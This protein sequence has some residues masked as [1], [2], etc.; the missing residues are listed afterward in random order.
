M[1]KVSKKR[2]I[3]ESDSDGSDASDLDQELLSLAS[4]AKRQKTSP[5]QLPLLT[6]SSSSTAAAAAGGGV[7]QSSGS[8]S[9]SEN[10]SDGEWNP[11]SKSK[12]AAAVVKV[13]KPAGRVPMKGVPHK[14]MGGASGGKRVV[15]RHSSSD[16]SD[17]DDEDVEGQG[18]P[19]TTLPSSTSGAAS[20]SSDSETSG[21]DDNDDPLAKFD[22][23][24]DEELVGDDEDRLKL[25][26]M[27][28]AER[29]Q[30]MYNR[31]EKR[32]ALKARFEIEQKL[33]RERKSKRSRQK[34]REERQK[35]LFREKRGKQ[36]DKSKSR[37]MDELKA[38]RTADKQ[39]KA[40]AEKQQQQRK[41]EP[42]KAQ[43]VYSSESEEE[44]ST[45]SSSTGSGGDSDD[46][47][48]DGTMAAL[49][50]ESKFV[51]KLEE[52][53]KIRLSR[54]RMEKW[55]HMPF[56]AETLIGCFARVGIG[57]HDGRMVYR[58]CEIIGV[59]E[60]P[61][62]YAL[63]SAKTNKGLKMRHGLQ[64]R[65]F[66]MEYVSNSALS[67]SEFSK[68]L[69]EMDKHGL[70]LPTLSAVA[71]KIKQLE[72]AKNFAL[73]DDDIEK[74]IQEKQK[75][76]K[77]PRNYAMTKSRLLRDKEVAELE[78]DLDRASNL[79]TK[80][81]ELE[82]RAEELDKQRSKGLSVISY[83]NERNRQRNVTRAELALKEEMAEEKTEDP[84]TRRKCQPTLVTLTR[85]AA[86]AGTAELLQ[87]LAEAQTTEEKE[88]VQA[89]LKETVSE[90][91]SPTSSNGQTSRLLDHLQPEATPIPVRQL[92]EQNP[93]VEDLFS[94]HDFDIQID[95]PSTPK[96]RSSVKSIPK[97]IPSQK[98]EGPKRSLN[99]ADYKKRKGLI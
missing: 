31:Y 43:D 42:L 37:A 47:T 4:A 13:K 93:D 22:D 54:F 19:G 76:R 64:E 56:F 70:P 65:L 26:L 80:I 78:G 39:R 5:D 18:G 12:K 25:D 51:S 1:S 45:S 99:L 90:L 46:D 40:E 49:R 8:G 67:E 16:S 28:E 62:V 23:G 2:P 21:S 97:V 57:A 11:E 61:K 44:E 9:S 7:G 36:T 81:G 14:K 79:G 48:G 96:D 92:T 38:K 55:V 63:G 69:K 20:S 58:V 30:E 72:E 35:R 75:F 71:K 91:L 95:L 53:S 94:A 83:I 29:E 10:D 88:A 77:N 87:Q 84:F 68:W 27:T 3:I 34:D 89:S 24:M 32:Q 15:A 33:R 50:K 59:Q 86:P 82:E 60:M 41:S 6:A 85:E 73:N 98:I 52:L 74:M 66:R 17:E